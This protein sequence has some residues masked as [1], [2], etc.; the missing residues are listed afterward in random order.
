[1]S[2]IAAFLASAVAATAADLPAPPTIPYAPTDEQ[3]CDTTTVTVYFSKYT[4]SLTEAAERALSEARDRLAGCQV[5]AVKATATFEIEAA[6]NAVRAVNGLSPMR[7]SPD[8]ALAITKLSFIN[9]MPA[10]GARLSSGP[11]TRLA[12]RS[13]ADGDRLQL[14]R[15]STVAGSAAKTPRRVSETSAR[16]AI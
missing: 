4:A 15:A 14:A 10:A 5:D 2:L 12:T 7:A 9:T 11:E 13:S 6:R 8:V 16:G 1:M 3:A